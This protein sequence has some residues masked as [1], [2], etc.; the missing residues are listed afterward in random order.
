MSASFVILSVEGPDS[1]EIFGWYVDPSELEAPYIWLSSASQN[2][3][4]LVEKFHGA[5]LDLLN[6]GEEEVES[7]EAELRGFLVHYLRGL[8]SA[9]MMADGGTFFVAI[10]ESRSGGSI[11][12]IDVDMSPLFRLPSGRRR[13]SRIHDE[14]T[15]SDRLKTDGWWAGIRIPPHLS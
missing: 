15:R 7:R 1:K 14:L 3:S 13:L 12:N 2:K 9:E 10:S 11:R 8:R 4:P 5:A 6:A